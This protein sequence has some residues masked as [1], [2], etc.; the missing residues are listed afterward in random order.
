MIGSYDVSRLRAYTAQTIL[1]Q[2]LKPVHLQVVSLVA[3]HATPEPVVVPHNGLAL[4]L[5]ALA[6]IRVR[7]AVQ[8]QLWGE[9]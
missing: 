4:F 2:R 6:H 9:H 5:P 8:D 7:G 1:K 3:L